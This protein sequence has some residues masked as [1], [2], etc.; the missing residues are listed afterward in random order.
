MALDLVT[1][2]KQ[3]QSLSQSMQEA[4]GLLHASTEDLQVYLQKKLDQNPCIVYDPPEETGRDGQWEQTGPDHGGW[5]SD[6]FSDA[7]DPYGSLSTSSGWR[8]ALL[9]QVRECHFSER[10]GWIAEQL[11]AMLPSS[12]YWTREESEA[13][14]DLLGCSREEV[15]RVVDVL[16]G[17]DPQGIFSASA[18][19][20][21]RR[22]LEEA[23]QWHED[24]GVLWEYLSSS[25]RLPLEVWSRQR[26][27]VASRGQTMM[28]CLK[29][30]RPYPTF[31]FQ[32]EEPW[33]AVALPLEST[34]CVEKN[35]S[36][37]WN[38]RLDPRSFPT[39]TV[40][41]RWRTSGGVPASMKDRW[42]DWGRE[43]RMIHR[44]LEQRRE[45]TMRVVESVVRHQEAFFLFGPGHLRPLTLQRLASMVGLHVSTV[46]RICHGKIVYGSFGRFELRRLFGQAVVSSGEDE[47]LSSDGLRQSLERLISEECKRSPWS[48]QQLCARLAEEGWKIARRTVAKYRE[49]WGIAPSSHRKQRG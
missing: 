42:R 3:S 39:I 38:I 13:A 48:D 31:G 7:R 9:W 33:S 16:R 34:I 25:P 8:E 29:R 35:T 14:P 40:D 11:T 5:R 6:G 17:L 30:L 26:G 19:D 45:H 12:G 44:A 21:L 36:G 20:F 47:A 49:Q 10:D 23:G 27:W 18:R 24:Y 46:S 15:D 2:Q 1:T 32:T 4:V 41:E 37:G 22:Q 28:D 43:A